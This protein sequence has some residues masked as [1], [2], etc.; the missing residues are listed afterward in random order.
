LS[1]RL[2]SSLIDYGLDVSNVNVSTAR[3]CIFVMQIIHLAQIEVLR[4][5]MFCDRLGTIIL[6][7]E[8]RRAETCRGLVWWRIEGN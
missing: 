5:V 1:A 4:T 7:D 3:H 6:R 8:D 2:N